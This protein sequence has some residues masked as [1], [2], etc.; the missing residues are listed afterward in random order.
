MQLS[1]EKGDINKYLI[2]SGLIDFEDLNI[3]QIANNLSKG[4]ENEIQIIKIVY[5]FVRDKIA[6]STDIGSNQV[7]YKASDV[8][9]YGHGLCFAKS[10]L[11]A[12]ILRFLGIPTGF[13]YQK[14]EFDGKIGLHGLNGVFIKNIDKWIRLDARGNENGINARFRIEN[15]CLAYNIKK[16]KG[17]LDFPTIYAQPNRKVIKILEKS[18]NLDEALDKVFNTS[19]L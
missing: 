4:A 8:L 19:W 7:I 5:E 16:E 11:L 14:I 18:S 9:K 10:H 17:E 13:C 3:Q 2:S 6:H 1:L 12:A 15:E